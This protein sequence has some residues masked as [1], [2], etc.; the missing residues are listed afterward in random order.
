MGNAVYSLDVA[1]GLLE[2]AGLDGEILFQIL[3]Y[4]QVLRIIFCAVEAIEG[5]SAVFHFFCHIK[6]PPHW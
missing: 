3:D 6:A 1:D 5:V 4:Q 2:E